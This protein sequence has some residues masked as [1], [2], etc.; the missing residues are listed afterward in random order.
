MQRGATGG[1]ERQPVVAR[2]AHE[3]GVVSWA[4]HSKFHKF[5][6]RAPALRL[7]LVLR[8]E[9][10]SI[11]RTFILIDRISRLRFWS[12][13]THFPIRCQIT[14]L[15]LHFFRQNR[16]NSC[17]RIT[18]ELPAIFFN[19]CLTHPSANNQRS[20]NIQQHSLEY[21]FHQVPDIQRNFTGQLMC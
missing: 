5:Q 10:S 15:R 3:D 20:F 2:P 6:C 8:P 13:L 9:R 4:F 18:N 14:F 12:R 19:I 21:H 1:Q 11:S 16:Q 7:W 17:Q